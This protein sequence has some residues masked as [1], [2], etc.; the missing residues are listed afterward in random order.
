MEELN[1]LELSILE[2]LSINYPSIKGHIP[3]L[4]VESRENTGVG[5]YINF[6]YINPVEKL[7]DLG[8]E[9]TSICTNEIIEMDGLKYGL[10]YEVDITDGKIKFI[11]IF[12]YGEEWD[13]DVLENFIFTK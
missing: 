6:S 12:T 5:M 2:R 9:N 7:L 11:E 13:G 1:K 10:G 4:R 8:I 3:F